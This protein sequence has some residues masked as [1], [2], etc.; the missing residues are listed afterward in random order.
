MNA[1][2]WFEIY[3]DNLPRAKKFYE[4]VLGKTL[5]ELKTPVPGIEMLSFPAEMQ[6]AGAGGALVKMEGL[7]AGSNSTLVY[8]HSEDCAIE[9]ARVVNAG[10]RIHCGKRTIGEHGFI[11]LAYDTE[12]NLFGLHSMK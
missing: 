8:F 10:G 2:I 11:T 7:S 9:E 4:T 6:S 1:V 3:V 12:G 5:Q